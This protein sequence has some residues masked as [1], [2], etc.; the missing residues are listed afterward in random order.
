M[1]VKFKAS[2]YMEIT[3]RIKTFLLS[4][5]ALFLIQTVIL[6][7]VAIARNLDSQLTARIVSSLVQYL[8]WK[9]RD[10][11]NNVTICTLGLDGVGNAIQRLGLSNIKVINQPDLS[12]LVGCHIV[13]ISIT[14]QE[15]LSELLWKIKQYQIVSVSQMPGF[16]EAGGT[17][18]IMTEVNKLSFKVNVTTAKNAKV[19]IDPDLMNDAGIVQ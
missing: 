15:N 19:V 8:K 5:C 17:I 9:E 16:V 14:E 6:N 3:L 12:A 2:E 1:K 18:Q 4:L 7:D 13:Y 10:Y 11:K